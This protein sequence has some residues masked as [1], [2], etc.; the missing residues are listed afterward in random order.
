MSALTM[1]EPAK[2]EKETKMTR[3]LVVDDHPIFRY[4]VKELIESQPD[5][6]VCGEA[7][8]P[9]EALRFLESHGADI[10]IVDISLK[11]GSGLELLKSIKARYNGSV[12]MLVSSMHDETLYAERTLAA[13]AMGYVSKSDATTRLVEALREVQRGN[14]YLSSNMTEQLLRRMVDGQ[15]EPE[16]PL[17]DTL[18]SRELE[19]LSLLGQG[20]TTRQAAQKLNLSVKT[21]ESHRENIKSKLNLKNSAQLVR[22]AVEWVLES[23]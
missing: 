10:V 20:L 3:I 21:I 8:D 9:A 14:V 13:G 12:K 5:F 6:R 11:K 17:I 1:R 2:S 19:V 7:E 16:R 23:A 15:K 4:G 22:Y 18:T